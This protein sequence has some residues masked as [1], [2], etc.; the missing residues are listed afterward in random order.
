[1]TTEPVT[2]GVPDPRALA[3][4][5]DPEYV[6]LAGDF[7]GEHGWARHVIKAAARAGS[8][9]VIQVGD[10]GVYPDREGNHFLNEVN[11][12]A[13]RT[14]VPVLFVDGNHE[15][16]DFLASFPIDP[17]S[18]LR[19][20]RPWVLH[21]PRGTRWTWRSLTW[22]AL[23]GATSLN[24][25]QLTQGFDWFPDEAITTGDAYR[26][27]SDGQADVMVTH[28]CPAGV[29]IP[30]LRGHGWS[31]RALM[32]AAAHQML[33]RQVVD[34]V[35]PTHLF[36]G[37]FHTRYSADLDLGEGLSCEVT[38]LDMNGTG[39]KGYLHLDLDI[40]VAQSAAAR[41]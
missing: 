12:W 11:R 17:A 15:D 14:G 13:E 16:F 20:L 23:C 6:T 19:A 21:A 32:D 37:H 3:A 30:G 8:Q 29:A 7:H 2:T 9:V 4:L 33:L 39:A 40:L 27:V 38:G 18:G 24:R 22:L 31:Q 34:A 25:D 35:R 41:P 28:D 1:M 26:A 10:F 5:A 36:H